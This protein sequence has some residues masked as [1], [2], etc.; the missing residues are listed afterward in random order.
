[1]LPKTHDL[2]GLNHLCEQAGVF[3]GVEPDQL[4]LLSGYA[5]RVRYPGDDPT[6]EEAREALVIAN[7]VRRF[8]RK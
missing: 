4:D 5:V 1:M 7:T 3:I 6:I 2:V 8:A